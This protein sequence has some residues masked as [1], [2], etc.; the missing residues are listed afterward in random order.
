MV[1]AGLRH[2][3]SAGRSSGLCFFAAFYLNHAGPAS[4]CWLHPKQTEHATRNEKRNAGQVS[5]ESFSPEKLA[6]SE[7]RNAPPQ[8]VPRRRGR[9]LPESV[10]QKDHPTGAGLP[11]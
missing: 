8:P 1:Y 7:A 5:E 9:G 3:E 2:G 4:A 10:H 6:E 11:P